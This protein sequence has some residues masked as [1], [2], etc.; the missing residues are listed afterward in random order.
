VAAQISDVSR[1]IAASGSAMNGPG[2]RRAAEQQREDHSS[3]LI[4]SAWPNTFGATM[5]PSICCSAVKR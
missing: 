5:W 2:S 3:G 4:R 1:R